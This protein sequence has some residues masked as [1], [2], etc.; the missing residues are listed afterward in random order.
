MGEGDVDFRSN[1]EVGGP[2]DVPEVETHQG[3][4]R[5]T[6]GNKA[7]SGITSGEQY[8]EDESNWD[9]Y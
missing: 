5:T 8:T 6:V 7:F 4:V 2:E 3:P 9:G 1:L